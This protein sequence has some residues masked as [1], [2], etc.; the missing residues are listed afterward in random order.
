MIKNSA[1]GIFNIANNNK[2][3]FENAILNF[4][5]NYINSYYNLSI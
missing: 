3:H 2:K 5:F 1:K 4:A